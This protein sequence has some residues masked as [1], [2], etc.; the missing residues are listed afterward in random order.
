MNRLSISDQ[1]SQGTT[2]KCSDKKGFFRRER[3]LVRGS[4]EC[5]HCSIDRGWKRQLARR[6]DQLIARYSLRTCWTNLRLLEAF[7]PALDSPVHFNKDRERGI[8]G[9]CRAK[10][11]SSERRSPKNLEER[12][13]SA[14]DV[15]LNCK[16][17]PTNCRRPW[18]RN[19]FIGTRRLRISRRR[20]PE[21][22][23]TAVRKNHSR[24]RKTRQSTPYST[25]GLTKDRTRKESSTP[26]WQPSRTCDVERSTKR[27][28]Y[29]GT[30]GSRINIAHAII[31]CKKVFIS[32]CESLY[33]NVIRSYLK[34]VTP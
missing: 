8:L 14:Y 18:W 22:P 31:D 26:G 7:K 25:V 34:R 23:S 27:K 20:K 24:K 3:S 30:D 33:D 9:C 28:S 29:R 1:M 13:N 6:A 32:S 17:S 5:T 19:L 11:L 15:P 4:L 16:A 2:W 21:V 10:V 12:R